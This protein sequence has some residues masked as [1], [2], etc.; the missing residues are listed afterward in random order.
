[1][2]FRL[3]FVNREKH[4]NSR[5]AMWC[6]CR[7]E[8]YLA[9][10]DRKIWSCQICSKLGLFGSGKHPRKKDCITAP[11]PSLW[12]EILCSQLHRRKDV[13]HTK[14]PQRH[15]HSSTWS[16]VH[17][18]QTILHE[19]RCQPSAHEQSENH[20]KPKLRYP[21]RRLRRLFDWN[22]WLSW[23]WIT[24]RR[25]GTSSPWSE[26]WKLGIFKYY[27]LDK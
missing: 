18:S 16:Q 3:K 11:F 9:K 23:N 15:G 19:N 6:I 12:W 14:S 17:R 20:E 1:M 7:L 25:R 21:W 24:R 27:I 22:Y 8:P 5:G 10:G 4:Q 26:K 13:W 2:G